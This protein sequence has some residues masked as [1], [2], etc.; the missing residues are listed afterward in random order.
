M[1]DAALAALHRSPSRHRT[2]P[3]PCGAGRCAHPGPGGHGRDLDPPAAATAVGPGLVRN[4]ADAGLLP[5]SGAPG[6][7]AEPALGRLPLPAAARRWP[8]GLAALADP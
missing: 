7:S 6:A 5:R 2:A 4:G 8:S 1:A 3:A